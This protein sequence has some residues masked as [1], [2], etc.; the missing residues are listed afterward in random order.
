M[1]G[2]TYE[3]LVETTPPKDRI[4]PDKARGVRS[5]RHSPPEADDS[6]CGRSSW[7]EDLMIKICIAFL[8]L[9][10]IHEKVFSASEES[11]LEF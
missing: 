8:V 7:S 9:V 1:R 4:V 3:E 2:G 6:D 10:L 5:A 11:S